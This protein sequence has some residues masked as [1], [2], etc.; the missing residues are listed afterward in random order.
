MCNKPT[1]NSY[2]MDDAFP[3]IS[4]SLRHVKLNFNT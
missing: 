1:E 2:K 3:T 4:M